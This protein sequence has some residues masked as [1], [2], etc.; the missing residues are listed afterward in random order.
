MPVQDCVI[1]K[2]Y[3]F[4]LRSYSFPYKSQPSLKFKVV[5]LAELIFKFFTWLLWI[6]LGHLLFSFHNNVMMALPLGERHNSYVQ[7]SIFMQFH[8]SN[9]LPGYKIIQINMVNV[10]TC[11]NIC[12]KL[13]KVGFVTKDKPFVT[14]FCEFHLWNSPLSHTLNRTKM[15]LSMQSEYHFKFQPKKNHDPS[16]ILC[17]LLPHCYSLMQ[18]FGFYHI[19]LVFFFHNM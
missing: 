4:L 12:D 14:N 17:A 2:W 18:Y 13:T 10:L 6:T 5:F 8:H 3:V 16:Y 15:C 1:Q 9:F 11:V 19:S 7:V